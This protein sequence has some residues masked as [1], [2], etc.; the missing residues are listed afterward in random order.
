MC[1]RLSLLKI[2]YMF[3]LIGLVNKVFK[4]EPASSRPDVMGDDVKSLYTH[5]R[6]TPMKPQK[7]KI[8]KHM[9]KCHAIWNKLPV[10][11]GSWTR[12]VV[13]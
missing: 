9:I 11:C 12:E 2:C 13:G 6:D 5:L 1:S 8:I 10:L 3:S 7:D 4:E